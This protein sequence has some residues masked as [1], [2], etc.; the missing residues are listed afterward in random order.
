MFLVMFF[1]STL[2]L[3]ASRLRSAQNEISFLIKCD[4]RDS[5]AMIAAKQELRHAEAQHSYFVQRLANS[6]AL[7][8]ADEKLRLC[9]HAGSVGFSLVG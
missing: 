6:M 4:L 2:G 3:V 9:N 5:R 1:E 8:S 7:M